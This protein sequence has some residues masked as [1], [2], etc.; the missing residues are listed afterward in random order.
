MTMTTPIGSYPA[1]ARA[2]ASTTP[3][4]PGKATAGRPT[5][6]TR[7]NIVNR[8]RATAGL[9]ANKAALGTLLATMV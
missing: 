2:P 5:V 7:T 6:S 9:E 3:V 4:P 1:P 8:V